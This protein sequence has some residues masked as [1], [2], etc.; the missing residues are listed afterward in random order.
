MRKLFFNTKT[1]Y[2]TL[3]IFLVLSYYR[4][5]FVWRDR[6][7]LLRKEFMIS[8]RRSWERRQRHGWLEILSILTFAKDHK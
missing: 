7:F 8:W 1:Q 3:L 4:E 2:L 6:V 5:K